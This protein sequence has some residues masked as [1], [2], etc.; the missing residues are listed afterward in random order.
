MPGSLGLTSLVLCDLR[1]SESEEDCVCDVAIVMGFGDFFF[2]GG[3]SLDDAE[4][5]CR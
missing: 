4:S 2:I 3:N 5:E 1:E